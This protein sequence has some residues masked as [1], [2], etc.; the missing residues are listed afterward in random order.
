V[1]RKSP[2]QASLQRL[3]S[4]EPEVPELNFVKQKLRELE[5]KT[6]RK[7]KIRPMPGAADELFP[8]E[9]LEPSGYRLAKR[10]KGGGNYA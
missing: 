1:A 9:Y 8:G 2:K 4:A 6:G 5:E 10:K 3:A 7:R